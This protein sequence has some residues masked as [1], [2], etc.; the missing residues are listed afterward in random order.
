MNDVRLRVRWTLGME[1]TVPQ[2]CFRLDMASS[3]SF[4]PAAVT[5]C[6]RHLFPPLAEEEGWETDSRGEEGSRSLGLVCGARQV[7]QLGAGGAVD[8]GQAG[9][10]LSVQ[11]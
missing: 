6:R 3:S 10:L 2:R 7:H 11:P 9:G 1:S 5:Q 8:G 4:L